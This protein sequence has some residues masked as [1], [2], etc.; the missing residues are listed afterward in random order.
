MVDAGEGE[1]RRTPAGRA[2]DDALIEAS[3]RLAQA[4]E[5][6]EYLALAVHELRNPATVLAGLAETLAALVD[7]EQLGSK[8]AEVL[9][10]IGRNARR[11]RALVV[12]ILQ[13]AYLDHGELPLRMAVLP[14]RPILG[15]AIE[16]ASVTGV[17]LDCDPLLHG[18]VDPDRLQQIV[19]NLVANADQHGAAPVVVEARPVGDADGVTVSVR[20]EGA[21]VG[22][23]EA[24]H[25]FDRFAELSARTESSTG[26]G[27][28]IA[29]DLAR[30]MAGDLIYL[31]T[32]QGSM[33][34][35]HLPGQGA[36][37]TAA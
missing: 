36:A 16:D 26:L 23:A 11:F 22:G 34:R 25:L 21:G 17:R 8:G 15:W 6:E 1:L 28:S 12:D 5:S 35:L 3:R 20:D 30:A 32:E 33:F 7:A 31:R 27:L 29:R 4:V 13:S 2:A 24:T 19:S 14:L 18:Y 10:S 37:S 9:A